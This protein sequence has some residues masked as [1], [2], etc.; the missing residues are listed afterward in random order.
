[1]NIDTQPFPYSSQRDGI[2]N[3]I[4]IIDYGHHEIHG[5]SSFTAYYSVTTA[6]TN[7]H[8]TGLFIKTPAAGGKLCHLIVSFAS[9]TAADA[10]ICEAPTIAANTGTHGVAIYNRYRDSATASGVYDNATVAAVN[11]FTTLTEAQIAGDGTWA[12]GTV[13]RS[14]PLAIGTGP[15]P[16]G[17]DGRDA[18]EYIL[19]ANTKYVFL[20]TNTAASANTHHI[21]IDWYEHTNVV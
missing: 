6:A 20:L 13:I 12:V 14:A 5:G 11:K 15:K 3:S 1:M 4:T 21:L 19:K 2:T 17:G 9:S 10:S 18:Q 8:R 7:G 16:A